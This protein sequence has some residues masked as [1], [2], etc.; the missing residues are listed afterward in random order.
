MENIIYFFKCSSIE[1]KRIFHSQYYF[2]NN[3]NNFIIHDFTGCE[4]F[5]T[6]QNLKD[7]M[8]FINGMDNEMNM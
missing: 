5:P 2:K 3:A 1:I 4:K 8:N 6:R 7:L